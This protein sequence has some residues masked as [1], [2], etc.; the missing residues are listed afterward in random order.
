MLSMGQALIFAHL[1]VHR[2]D[3]EGQLA[4]PAAI[5]RN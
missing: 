1:I 2:Y 3:H 5:S 4:S